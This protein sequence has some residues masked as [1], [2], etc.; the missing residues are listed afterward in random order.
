MEALSRLGVPLAQ[1]FLLGRPAPPWSS[2]DPAVAARLR[3]VHARGQL[4]ENVVSIVEHVPLV[5]AGATAPAAR[6]AVRVDDHGHPVALLLPLRRDHDPR[7]HRTSPVS[8][9]V[10]ASTGIA[11]LAR[12]V[13]TRPDDTRLDPVV[14]V[15]DVGAVIGI[16][17]VEHLLTRLAEQHDA[18]HP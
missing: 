3:E 16:V 1:G 11:E 14:C 7:G 8:L 15:D 10:P 6:V 5:A 17:R 12:R 18:Q 13:S 2:V 9:R 4:R